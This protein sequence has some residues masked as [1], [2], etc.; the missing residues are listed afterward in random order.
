[1]NRINLAMDR[2][3]WYAIV[4]MS[5]NIRFHKRQ[6]I[7]WLSE[8]LKAFQRR[9]SMQYASLLGTYQ[10]VGIMTAVLVHMGMLG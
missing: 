4:N 1:M 10:Y 5:W 6:E 3:E 9:C 7:S 2:D 8:E